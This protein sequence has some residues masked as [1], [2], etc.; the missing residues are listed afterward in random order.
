MR[1]ITQNYMIMGRNWRKG[2]CFGSLIPQNMKEVKKDFQLKPSNPSLRRHFLDMLIK[3]RFL[4][5][6]NI[7]LYMPAIWHTTQPLK[8]SS[9]V[10]SIADWLITFPPSTK[11]SFCPYQSGSARSG[12]CEC[13]KCLTQRAWGSYRG[14]CWSLSAGASGAAVS[15][16]DAGG[17][18]VYKAGLNGFL[19]ATWSV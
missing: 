17:W 8:K 18:K 14:T 9:G 10:Q 12:A 4:K 6:V 15:A 16:A 3:R 11:Q 7:V 19:T 5:R 13:W 2:G 1:P